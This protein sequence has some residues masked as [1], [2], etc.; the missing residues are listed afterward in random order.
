MTLQPQRPRLGELLLERG[1]ITEV[2][3]KEALAETADTGELLGRILIGKRWLFEDEL[4]RAL[5]EQLGIPYVSLRSAGVDR[6]LARM[7]PADIGLHYAAIPIGFMGDRLR[8]AFADPCDE[9]ATGA[10][11]RHFASYDPVVA[12]LSEIEFVWRSITARPDR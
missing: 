9:S 3:L 7:L 4:A 5:A 12:E 2:Q 1:L 8:V 10:V 11:S 6:A